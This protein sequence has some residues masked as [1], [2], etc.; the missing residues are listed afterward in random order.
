MSDHPSR[1][2]ETERV[3]DK[4]YDVLSEFDR[5]RQE[6]DVAEERERRSHVERRRPERRNRSDRRE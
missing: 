2:D 4:T 6:I 3:V 5:V 1:G